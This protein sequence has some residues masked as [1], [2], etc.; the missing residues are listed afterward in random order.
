MSHD[1]SPGHQTRQMPDTI[2]TRADGLRV[3]DRIF[4]QHDGEDF[5][6]LI[7][8]I[9]LTDDPDKLRF[10][11][12]LEFECAPIGTC[13]Q[14]TSLD[15]TFLRLLPYHR[16]ADVI[17]A[18]TMRGLADAAVIYRGNWDGN[19]TVSVHLP[20]IVARQI[21]GDRGWENVRNEDGAHLAWTAPNGDRFWETDE[22]V[23]YALTAECVDSPPPSGLIAA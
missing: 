1:M 15:T 10:E 23:R 18:T 17:P 20:T 13:T 2:S 5:W 8:A 6:A 14:T 16:P 7:I 9:K 22:A 19:G 4:V 21:L 3:F 12:K 11:L